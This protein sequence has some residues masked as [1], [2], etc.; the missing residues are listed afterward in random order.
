LQGEVIGAMLDLVI[1]D[2]TH[3]KRSMDDVMR[4][5][6]TRF[7]TR[8]FT[9]NDIE[10]VVSEVC[11]CSVREIFDRH[12]RAGNPIDFDRYLATMGL[13]TNVS[14]TPASN[15][16]GTP[17]VDLR[18][19]GYETT[20]EQGLRLTI[21]D[22]NSVW[23]KAGLNSR[24]RLVT[25]NSQPLTTWPELRAV[26]TSLEIGDTVDFV[27]DR[28]SGQFKTRVHVTGF[29][30]PV[31]RIDALDTITEQQ[32]QLREDW[33]R[34]LPAARAVA[35]KLSSTARCSTARSGSP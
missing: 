22:P 21:S 14:W 24:D 18:I 29:N 15:R 5:M 8:G 30:R 9:G 33:L 26:L 6:N 12:V 20:N 7:A 32:R 13:R 35:P 25:I 19:W 23:A 1:R 16:D 27:V 17:A 4:V 2:A 11:G 34:G 31:V 3:G 10:Q 28:P